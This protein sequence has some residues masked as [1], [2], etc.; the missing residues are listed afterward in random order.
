MT[1]PSRIIHVLPDTELSRILDEAADEVL[2][3]AME[4]RRYRLIR[5][6]QPAKR[7]ERPRRRRLQPDRVLDII[8]IGAS[9]EDTNIARYK[10]EYLAEA[11]D[12]R[13][14]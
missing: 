8:G 11:A 13:D 10:D 7:R 14:R 6:D 9:A 12:R 3:L 1:K 4:G 5:D 2:I